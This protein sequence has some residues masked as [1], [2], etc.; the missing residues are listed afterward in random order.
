[1]YAELSGKVVIISGAGGNL[2]GAV[3]KRLYAENVRLALVDRNE[4]GLK[5]LVE[6][7]GGDTSNLMTMPIDLTRKS[8]VDA[9]VE[10][11]VETW[12]TLDIMVNTTGGF[13]TSPVHEMS[14][15]DWDFLLNLNAKTAFLLSGAAARAMIANG[16]QGRI[17]HISSRAALAG[18]AGLAAYSASKAAVLR[19]TESMA[20]ELLDYGIMVNAVLPSTLDTPPNRTSM[21]SA[22]FSRW[23]S[24]ASLADVIAFLVSDAAR[25]ISGASIP[26]YGRS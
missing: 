20:A 1:M 9:F 22:D 6:E 14:E 16:V 23:V 3:A 12:G 8:E 17:I 19:L 5:T 26:V 11:L 24:P 25:D 18:A 2:G 7:L 21:P 13:K 4:A 15:S 10:H